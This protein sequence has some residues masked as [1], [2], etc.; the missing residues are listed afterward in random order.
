MKLFKLKD[1][2]LRH[3]SKTQFTTKLF[4][5]EDVDKLEVSKKGMDILE[6]KRILRE[7]TFKKF[8]R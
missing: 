3:F 8:K 7:G 6:E 1:S 4:F 5:G 2:I